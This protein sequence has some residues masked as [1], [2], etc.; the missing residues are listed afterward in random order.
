MTVQLLYEAAVVSVEARLLR[1]L[2]R[3]LSRLV[4]LSVG[5]LVGVWVRRRSDRSIWM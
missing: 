1:L 4:C 3:Q 2:M 5:L